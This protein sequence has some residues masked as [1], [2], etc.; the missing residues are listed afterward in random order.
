[1][2]VGGSEGEVESRGGGGEGEGRGEDEGVG[3]W[4][5]MVRVMTHT[6]CFARPCCDACANHQQQGNNPAIN[7]L[8]DLCCLQSM[9]S[10]VVETMPAK[11]GISVFSSNSNKISS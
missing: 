10:T 9:A 1:M 4:D 2:S 3:G 8:N 11:S 5:W 6:K 7:I